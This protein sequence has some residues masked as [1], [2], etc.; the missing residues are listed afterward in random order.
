MQFWLFLITNFRR[1]L[2]V[3]CF[4]FSVIPRRLKFIC[5][6][7]G[8][9]CSISIGRYIYLPMEMEQCLV[10]WNSTYA[11]CSLRINDKQVPRNPLLVA[12][13]SHENSFFR[14]RERERVFPLI[15]LLEAC[16]TTVLVCV[17]VC[18]CMCARGVCACVVYVCVCDLCVVRVCVVCVC[19]W[20]A[21]VC[22][23]VVCVSESGRM[24]NVNGLYINVQ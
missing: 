13:N 20:C 14:E 7:F 2:N 23:C 4:F 5:R 3:A 8:T 21:C 18:M 19:V 9:L 15:Y 10:N 1:V 22:V 12:W 16:S 6:R 24:T 17:C 11:F